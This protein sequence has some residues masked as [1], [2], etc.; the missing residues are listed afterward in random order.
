ME[1][2]QLWTSLPQ[3]I[4]EVEG[5]RAVLERLVTWM[6]GGN[7]HSFIREAPNVTRILMPQAIFPYRAQDRVRDQVSLHFS[8]LL[9]GTAAS[10][11]NR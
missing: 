6:E 8:S 11:L 3:D 10:A 4:T 9:L 2:L 1:I 5:S 7:H